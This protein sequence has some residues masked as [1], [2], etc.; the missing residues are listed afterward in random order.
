MPRIYRNV[1]Y[2]SL[3]LA[4]V[5]LAAGFG[6]ARAW[7]AL[8]AFLAMGLFWLFTHKQPGIW[9]SSAVLIAYL[10]MTCISLLSGSSPLL[11][12]LGVTAALASWDLVV[13]ERSLAGAP[14]A[15]GLRRL[16]RQHLACLA[17]AA[18]I[19]LLSGFAGI[20]IRIKL[21]FGVIVL[22]VLIAV[23]GIERGWRM[24]RKTA[25]GG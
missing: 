19:G 22:L 2:L 23:V 9:A 18:G 4:M 7:L 13:F 6:P 3:G 11:A 8:P 14:P 15:E 12:L 24:L 1:L 25:I 20:S 17:F 21:P 10:G 16:E 5:S